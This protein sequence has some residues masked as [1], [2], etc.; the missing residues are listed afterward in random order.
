VVSSRA[1][2]KV[3]RRNHRANRRVVIT[4]V[5]QQVRARG[6]A[7]KANPPEKA[8]AVAARVNRQQRNNLEARP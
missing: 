3:A 1:A 8:S 7:A 2:V 4:T 6:A 5:S